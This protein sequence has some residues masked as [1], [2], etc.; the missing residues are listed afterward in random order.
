MVALD[1]VDHEVITVMGNMNECAK[2]CAGPFNSSNSHDI[3]LKTGMS[4][5]LWQLNVSQKD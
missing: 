5:S 3:P 4:T 2:L 1:E